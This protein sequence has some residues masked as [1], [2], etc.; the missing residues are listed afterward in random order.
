VTPP[1]TATP[2]RPLPEHTLVPAPARPPTP[3]PGPALV[4]R[5]PQ[6]PIAPT[7]PPPPPVASAPA[8]PQGPQ[9]R[10]SE[11]GRDT[12]AAAVAELYGRVGRE[13]KQ[14]AERRGTATTADLWPRYRRIRINEVLASVSARAST[15]DELESLLSEI[16][17]RRAAKP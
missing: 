1:L 13:L 3:P 11:T 5:L 6:V 12:S 17:T 2:P 10:P 8:A 15:A 9:P 16:A 14:L 4:D 7:A